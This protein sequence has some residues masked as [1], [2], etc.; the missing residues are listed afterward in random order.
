[1]D[2][3]DTCRQ[4]PC[5]RMALASGGVFLPTGN[6]AYAHDVIH[7]SWYPRFNGSHV[8]LAQLYPQMTGLGGN[9]D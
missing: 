8:G 2:L 6:G 1:M 3:D 9:F 4:K 5:G 7:D